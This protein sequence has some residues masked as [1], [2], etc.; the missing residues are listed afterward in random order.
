[1]TEML[2]WLAPYQWQPLV[3]LSCG[4]VLLAYLRGLRRL[5][6]AERPGGARILAFLAGLALMYAVSQTVLDYFA[7]Y[8]F[9]VH[10]LQHLVL[11]HLGPFL[12]AL[13]APLPVLAAGLPGPV[14]RGLGRGWRQPLVQGGYRAI[15][16]PLVA[17]LLFVGLI[18]FWLMPEIHFIAMLSRGLYEVM[19]WSMALDG[20]LFWWLILNPAPPG[21]SQS[22]GYGV[23]IAVLVGI[24]VP[25]ILL[26]AY[27]TLGGPGL[28]DVYDVCGRAWP[29][30]PATDQTI[31]GVVTWIPAAMMSLLG[32]LVVMSYAF[33]DERHRRAENTE[34]AGAG[35]AG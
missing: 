9:F 5:A 17:G 34:V 8:M 14:R 35:P 12:V 13:A 33:R 30:D 3:T 32:V 15:Q 1:M 6:P 31:G 29:L 27:I 23:R 26:G 19:N 4:I 7:Q 21:R 28:Y 10:R 25:Q 16:Q 2:G 22:I 24:V 20:L 11:H 18:Y